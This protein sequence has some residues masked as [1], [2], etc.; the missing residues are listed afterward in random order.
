MVVHRFFSMLF[1]CIAFQGYSQYLDE[2]QQKTVTE[3]LGQYVG[4]A[5]PGMAVGIVKDGTIVFESYLGYANLEHQVPIDANTRFN[6]ASNAKQFTALCILQLVTEGK[7]KLEED[8]R[9]YLPD[10]YQGI[11]GKITLSQLLTHTSGV[12]DV[13]DLWALKG[14]TWW[15]L[16]VG[17]TDAMALLK[18]QSSLNF[19][20]GTEYLYSNSNYIL[21]TEIIKNSTGTNFDAHA[22]GVFRSLGM[23]NSSFLTNYM[24]VV[25]HKARPY[26]NWNGWK[27]YPSITEIHGDGGL[28][29]TLRDQ[30]QW[31]AIIQNN[32][33]SVLPKN[34]VIASQAP[35]ENAYTDAY[36]F[37]LMFDSYKGLDYSY[38]DGN[39]GA[40]NAT[41]LR[42]PEYRTS[43][44]VLSNNGNIS[45]HY[46]A[47]QLADQFLE[48]QET[49]MEYPAGPK[50]VPS[51]LKPSEIVGSYQSE[52]GT[53]ITIQAKNDT[54][55]RNIYQRD[56]VALIP[57]KGALY[58]YASNPDLKMAFE[59]DPSGV[60]GFT[61]YLST[62]KP[63]SYKKLPQVVLDETYKKALTG[64]YFND[65]T[66]TTIAI[67]YT[68]DNTFLITKNGRERKAE[69]LYKDLLAMNSYEIR[70]SRDATGAIIG[71]RVKNGRIKNVTFKRQSK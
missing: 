63:I 24:E 4:D 42:F 59:K 28:F 36:G 18:D 9:A 67:D 20:P 55:F 65:E 16:F 2:A 68:G 6:I 26:G 11:D 43:I 8:I 14:Q 1:A 51:G 35:V 61:I 48:L 27:E 47:K 54:L 64:T 34:L 13:Y 7:L 44:V 5:S 12:R 19:G 66:Q 15:Q 46:V 21:L 10:L 23:E 33:G 38:H 49:K 32:D 50:T 31:E 71:L 37:G 39:T 57:E 53:I 41:F 25:P 22:Q 62:Q 60:S 40:Y 56:P 70:V 69:L 29:T 3:L 52:D 58:R 45:T 17:N 30:L